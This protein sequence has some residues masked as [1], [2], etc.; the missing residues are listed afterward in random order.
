M[1]E[2][3]IKVNRRLNAVLIDLLPEI[4]MPIQQANRNE[5]QIE[6]ARRLA[7]V[8]SEYAETAGII[9]DRFVKTEFSGEIGDRIF[10]CAPGPRLSVSVVSSEI[11]LEFLKDLLQFTQESFVL[12]KL[13]QPGLP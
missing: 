11:F 7:V 5:I 9:R 2:I 3:L 12:C 13:L 1:I 6:I 8:A 4:P 10:D